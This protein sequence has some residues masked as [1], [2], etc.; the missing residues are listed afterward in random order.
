MSARMIASIP[1]CPQDK[2]LSLLAQPALLPGRRQRKKSVSTTGTSQLMS[3]AE[4]FTLLGEGNSSFTY[5]RCPPARVP[6]QECKRPYICI[7]GLPLS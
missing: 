5:T 6:L 7:S 4:Y 2:G 3:A 1:P